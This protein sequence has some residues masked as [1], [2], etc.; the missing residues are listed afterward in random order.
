LLLRLI[1]Y[2]D[3]YESDVVNYKGV[4]RE[5]LRPPGAGDAVRTH[6]R[7]GHEDDGATAATTVTR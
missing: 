6:R 1:D 4:R 2:R 3:N 7:R 5:V